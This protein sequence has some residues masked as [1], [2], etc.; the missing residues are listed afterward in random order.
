MRRHLNNPAI[1][2]PL[3]L[4]ALAWAAYSYGLVDFVWGKL[5]AKAESMDSRE[6]HVEPS[7]AA[8]SERSA[9]ALQGLIRGPWL[10]ANWVRESAIR[11]EPFVA[12]Y[13]FEK[14]QLPAPALP[15]IEELEKRVVVDRETFEAIIS[16][17]L[18]LDRDGFFVV[19]ENVLNLP[20]RKRVGD[21]VYL[22][23]VGPLKIPTFGIAE[24]SRSLEE[25]Q[26]AIQAT[27]QKM[28]LQ[29]VGTESS[30]AEEDGTLAAENDAKNIAFIEVSGSSI[31]IY[32]QGE[33]VHRNPS[34]GLDRISKGDRVD[35]VVLVDIYQNEY[36]LRA[37]GMD[38]SFEAE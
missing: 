26:R 3:A 32:R 17:K 28:K 19:F 31:E 5:F 16:S 25:H 24:Q 8:A 29:G 10:S 36:E 34:L 9:L 13:S 21:E 7:S 18:G 14:K 33:L 22:Q 12:E 27:L 4:L 2:L 30:R 35:R 38:Q 1:V 15:G 11:K 6:E 37:K 23:D 20:V